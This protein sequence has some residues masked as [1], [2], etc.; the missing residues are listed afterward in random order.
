MFSIKCT[1]GNI[2]IEKGSHLSA[3]EYF[4]SHPDKAEIELNC[5]KSQ[6]AN[7]IDFLKHMDSEH[8]NN[9]IIIERPL[10]AKPVL[11]EQEQKWFSMD[12]DS[13]FI[14]INV[15]EQL[16]IEPLH[17]LCC[18]KIASE[19]IGNKTEALKHKFQIEDDFTAEEKDQINEF[20]NWVDIFN[21]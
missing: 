10:R 12:I 17:N 3:S 7:V 9:P 6:L 8:K 21:K 5:T 11:D 15:A 1:D 19:I 2:N 20:F 13:T 18:A 14:Y 16:G 4:I